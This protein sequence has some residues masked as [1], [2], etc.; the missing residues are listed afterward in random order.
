[1]KVSILSGTE[2]VNDFLKAVSCAVNL[3]RVQ[4]NTGTPRV[5]L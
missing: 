4:K 2:T 3:L 1:L 5:N